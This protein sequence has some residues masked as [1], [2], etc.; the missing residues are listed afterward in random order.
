MKRH[1]AGLTALAFLILIPPLSAQTKPVE[2]GFDMG[3]S[4]LLPDEEEADNVTVIGL[5]SMSSSWGTGVVRFGFFVSPQ[6]SIEPS[7][8]LARWSSED[9]SV[10]AVQIFPNLVYHFKEFEMIPLPY[11]RLGAGLNR[12]SHSFDGESDSESQFGIGGGVGVKIPFAKT[13]FLRLEGGYDKWLEG[14]KEDG[15]RG[16]GAIRLSVGISAIIN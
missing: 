3:L 5:P 4:I 14:D 2:F 13:A 11:V 1:A 12:Q 8:S 9:N 16:F 15:A 6:I 7:I 10:T